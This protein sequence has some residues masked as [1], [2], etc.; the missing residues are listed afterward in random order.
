MKNYSVGYICNWEGYHFK[1]EMKNEYA[2]W[3]SFW[4]HYFREGIWKFFHIISSAKYIIKLTYQ[5]KSEIK[6][7]WFVRVLI[8]HM[9]SLY[10]IWT[11]IIFPWLET[12]L[13]D[14][15]KVLSVLTCKLSHKYLHHKRCFWKSN[16]KPT[17]VLL[18][19]RKQ[20]FSVYIESLWAAELPVPFLLF[21]WAEL[22][23]YPV[24]DHPVQV[25][26]FGT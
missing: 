17:G 3:Y 18:Q 10:R 22:L 8:S 23:N 6:R 2:Y 7:F 5:R 14:R 9:L 12:E 1:L 11:Q 21:H 19:D 16:G 13:R 26:S 25:P 24:L 20:F 15:A 4:W